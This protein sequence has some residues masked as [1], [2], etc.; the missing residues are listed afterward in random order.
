[1]QYPNRSLAGANRVRSAAFRATCIAGMLFLLPAALVGQQGEYQSYPLRYAEVGEVEAALHG[2]LVGI[3]G[4]TDVIGDQRSRRI[5][6]RGSPEAQRLARQLIDSLDQPAAQPA[7]L[8]PGSEHVFKAY[9][10]HGADLADVAARWQA[11][12]AGDTRVR[13]TADPRRRQIL[14]VAPAEVHAQLAS[15]VPLPQPTAQIGAARSVPASGPAV[16]LAPAMPLAPGAGVTSAQLHN[17]TAS[18]LETALSNLW[19]KQITGGAP[20]GTELASYVVQFPSGAKAQLHINR[21]TNQAVVWAAPAV[22]QTCIKLIK[23]LDTRPAADGRNTSV[24]PFQKADPAKVRLALDAYATSANARQAALTQPGDGRAQAILA[25]RIFRRQQPGA[26]QPAAVQ[27]GAAQPGAAQPGVDQPPAQPNQPPAQPPGGVGG[28]TAEQIG[29]LIGNVRVEVIPELGI[30]IIEGSGPDVERMRQLIE[31][32]ESSIEPPVVEIYPLQHVNSTKLATLVTTLYT[33][34]YSG[35]AGSVSVTALVKPNALLI[36]GQPD[37]VVTIRDLVAKL[38]Q[39][40]SPD[41]EFQVF[42]L[43]HQPVL[44]VQQT[45]TTFFAGRTGLGATVLV[46]AD[47]RT[48]SL[49]V[50]AS[51]SDMAEVSLLL[52]QIDVAESGAVNELRIVKLENSLAE[53]LAE[54]LN[55]AITSQL[56]TQSRTGTGGGGFGGQLGGGGAQLGAAAGGAAGTAQ[57]QALQQKSAMLQFLTIDP[58]GQRIIK[59]GILTDVRV[60]ADAR[61]NSLIISAPADSMEMLVLLVRQL[62]QIP[63]VVAQ[64]KVFM[65]VNGDA[66]TLIEMLE[67]LFGATQTGGG[68]GGGQ[69]QQQQLIGAGES[70]LV[71]MRFSVDQRTNS[72]IAT[73]SAE[74]LL[75]VEAILLKLDQSDTRQRQSQIYRLK[76]APA[77]DVA[78]AINEFL[79][80]VRTIQQ[81]TPGVVTPFQQIEQEVV[82]VAE[83][84][85]NSLILSATPRYFNEVAALIEKL[86]SPPPMVV[87][88][89]LVGEVALNNSDEF[90][91]ELGIQDSVLFNR[92]LL[93][94]IQ[95]ITTTTTQ[96]IGNLPVTTTTQQIQAA[97]ATPGFNFN[98]TSA[99]GNSGSDA[100]LRTAGTLGGQALTN[101]SV[102]RF[103][104]EL[105]FGGMVLSAGSE[106][107][108]F[109]LRALSESR[110]F[111]VLSRPQVTTLD[112]QPAFIQVGQRVPTITASTVSTAGQSNAIEFVNV[113]LIMGVTPRIS[114]DGLVTMEIDAERSEV[115]PESEG[116]PVSISAT[117]QIVRSPRINTTTAQ[118]TVSALSGETIVLGG[119]LT[120]SSSTIRRRV[121]LLSSIPIL[122]NL[123]RYDGVSTRKT[124]L[125]IVLTPH[126]VRTKEDAEL[127]K[128]VESARMHWC[129]ADVEQMHGA[130]GL[131]NRTHDWA[132]YETTVVYPD[133]NPRGAT[134]I[135]GETPEMVPG[136]MP[137]PASPLPP[138]PT[139]GP[140]PP[141]AS[142]SLQ[143]SP[144]VA[145]PGP[146]SPNTVPPAGGAGP[147]LRP[148][149]AAKPVVEP[150]AGPKLFMSRL[151]RGRNDS[152]DSGSKPATQTAAGPQPAH[153][154]SVN[155]QLQPAVAPAGPPAPNATVPALQPAVGVQ[156]AQYGDPAA[157]PGAQ[158]LPPT[159]N[160]GP[161]IQA[162]TSQQP[163]QQPVPQQTY[164]R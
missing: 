56:S 46:T 87:I 49:I 154:A 70:S 139:M 161:Q 34:V 101:L 164:Y 28:L 124:E 132:D 41:T 108:S 77:P 134:P 152:E 51:P 159:L 64:I 157:P 76:T 21:R 33:Q 102:G 127:I 43:Q 52:K 12:F 106:S 150:S 89:V 50:Q 113:G 66:S 10:Y 93:E 118:T 92:S 32:I 114:Y 103:N 15:I 75:L 36:V 111:E 86:D 137:N 162:A 25:S 84:V 23:A 144:V 148:N 44:S 160:V 96:Q 80:S 136:A 116:I 83:P 81:A 130:V 122:G 69:Q 146:L 141:G 147:S 109:L 126:V 149:A 120:K 11:Q 128:N 107:L 65:I 143:P 26:A 59:S 45:L 5:L 115:G 79:T 57:N 63:A 2:A 155:P 6:L 4:P 67:S 97:T 98:S 39:P 31:L 17:I 82:I 7:A 153:R 16:T 37:N 95:N 158:R 30:I 94:N 105:G 19:G 73:G 85:S 55:T 145:P 40:V 1:M 129:L 48:N 140:V 27:P 13:V 24:I 100:A 88:Q 138:P 133:A 151:W 121:P 53:D 71:P 135:T 47:F 68:G 78:N 99:L 22:G 38:D 9:A 62:D 58:Q 104:S 156:Q 20:A 117:G 90:G 112:N 3:N 60:T 74:N 42:R 35:R 61:A 131:R 123:F 54:V 163:V 119:L 91:I 8:G 29:A 142:P 125:L 18:Q 14:V 110:R 72:V